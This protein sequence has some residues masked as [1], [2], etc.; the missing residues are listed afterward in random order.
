[1]T[2]QSHK[3]QAY[4]HSK[5]KGLSDCEFGQILSKEVVSHGILNSGVGVFWTFSFS[6]FAFPGNYNHSNGIN[7]EFGIPEFRNSEFPDFS[8]YYFY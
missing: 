7:S 5:E 4:Y 2:V 1:M 8:F 3:N 6:K